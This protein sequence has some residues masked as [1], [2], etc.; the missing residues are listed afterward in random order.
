MRV[1]L[2]IMW[3]ISLHAIWRTL[4][5]SAD[6]LFSVASSNPALCAASGAQIRRRLRPTLGRWS[7]PGH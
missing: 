5:A 2:Q 3:R 7:P 6:V 4:S 1:T